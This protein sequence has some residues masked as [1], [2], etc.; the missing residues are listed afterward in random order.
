[1]AG[2]EVD[3]LADLEGLGQPGVL[4]RGAEAGA[5]RG[6]AGVAA[7]EP[8]DAAVGAA[9]PRQ[10]GEQGGLAGAVGAE[11]PDDLAG[12]DAQAD[13]VE[14]D[15]VPEPPGGVLDE[16]GRVVGDGGCGH[17]WAPLSSAVRVWVYRSNAW[18]P[19]V[20]SST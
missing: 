10:Q 13:V 20:V 11:Q 14:R 7:E 6:V 4:R 5:R 19:A 15:D 12:V 16:D 2:D 1:M 3:D 18:R 17:G 8:D 9:Q